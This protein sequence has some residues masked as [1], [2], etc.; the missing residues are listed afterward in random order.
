MTIPSSGDKVYNCFDGEVKSVVFLEQSIS[1]VGAT[2]ETWL[3]V[4]DS[5]REFRCPTTMYV[6][7]KQEALERYLD[8]LKS[9]HRQ[10]VKNISEESDN[11]IR[12]AAEIDR[13]SALIDEERL[14]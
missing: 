12:C 10:I 7:T 13:V 1:G 3:C 8:N 2:A 6:T 5:G 4:E 11:L 9:S 14:S